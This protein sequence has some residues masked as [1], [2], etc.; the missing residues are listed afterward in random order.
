MKLSMIGFKK[1]PTTKAVSCGSISDISLRNNM[2]TFSSGAMI[3]S[4]R[5]K[6]FFCI[7]KLVVTFY[8]ILL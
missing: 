4:S 8:S 6:R 5:V 2:I 3:I 7:Y 1:K